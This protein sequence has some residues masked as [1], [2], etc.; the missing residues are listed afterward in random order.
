MMSRILSLLVCLSILTPGLQAVEPQPEDA[1]DAYA[2]LTTMET[3]SEIMRHLYR[4]YLDEEDFEDVLQSETVSFWVMPRHPRLDE[5]DKS[6]YADVYIPSVDVSVLMKKTDYTIEEIDLTAVSDSFKI[7]NVEK[8]RESGERPSDAISAS[9][10]R[11]DMMAYL[12][13]TRYQTDP[14]SPAL[15][16]RL[17]T[18]AQEEVRKRLDEIPGEDDLTIFVAP[19]SPVAN[20][21]WVFWDD[22]DL[23]IEWSSDIDLTNESVWEQETLAVKVID[24]EEQTVLSFSEAPGSNAYMTRDQIGRILYNCVVLGEK[25]LLPRALLE[26]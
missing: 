13:R 24:I 7:V 8:V 14:A 9:F 26:K 10:P 22:A 1:A 11:S 21:A 20:E 19:I 12:F 18:A 6:L 3:I 23:L 4:W 17:R 5:G 15:G 16:A 2:E 25:R